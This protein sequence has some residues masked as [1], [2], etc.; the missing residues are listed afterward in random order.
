MDLHVV[1]PAATPEERAAI[2][3]VLDPGDRGTEVR[4]G[5]RRARSRG[6]RPRGAW[7]ARGPGATRPPAARARG[8]GRARSAGSAAARSTT[9]RSGSRSRPPRPTA[10]RR[11]TPCSRRPRGPRSWPTCATT[12]PAGS[13]GAERICEDLERRHGPAGAATADGVATWLRSPC[14][15]QCER[16]PAVLVTS[17]G[18]Q[19]TAH[20]RGDLLR[21][22]R[23]DLDAG[24]RHA[25][26]RTS[27][28]DVADAGDLAPQAGDPSLRLLTRVGRVDPTSLDAYRDDGGY[29]A[30]REA[31][32]MGP[33]AVIERGH[34][35]EARRSRRR[36]VPDRPQVGRGRRASRRRRTTSCATPTSPSRARSRTG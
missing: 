35:V 18:A 5:R 7:R 19:P 33:N 12:S 15:G 22:R 13:P 9:S 23:R 17:A 3:A 21:R 8:G 31:L 36:R 28:V 29:E 20:V 4:L 10:S 16:A 1:G 25:C 34:R 26:P 27:N 32:A 11:S 14:L 6:R 24:R 30:L 2:D